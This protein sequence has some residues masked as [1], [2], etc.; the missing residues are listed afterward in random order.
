ME[1]DNNI[2]QYMNQFYTDSDESVA[3][4]SI[5]PSHLVTN[6]IESIKSKLV[7]TKDELEK[8][9][10]YAYEKNADDIKNLLT[11][12]TDLI[13]ITKSVVST[14]NGLVNPECE[15]L[16]KYFNDSTTKIEK[17]D[18]G[19]YIDLRA[20]KSYKIKKGTNCLVNL[21]IAMQLPEGY[22]GQILPR[23]STFKNYGVILCNSMGIIDNSYRGETDWWM[24]NLYCIKPNINDDILV[25][26]DDPKWLIKLYKSNLGKK[27][28]KKFFKKTWESHTY[29]QIN[30]GDRLC[31]F[32]ITKNMPKIIFNET[33]FNKDIKSRGGFGTTGTE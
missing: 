28:L 18:K 19:D 20:V 9:I 10:N 13:S 7:E 4:S 30:K 8:K 21:G 16:I 17:I 14:V 3:L 22:E 33:D 23:S 6:T 15:I 29:T 12:T 24:A 5:N 25:D 27:I 11:A 1:N 26:S 31:Q 32:R 2:K